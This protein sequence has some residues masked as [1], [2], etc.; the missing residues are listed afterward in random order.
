MSARR[1]GRISRRWASGRKNFFSSP[2]HAVNCSLFDPADAGH[3]A[4][5]AELWK[6]LGLAPTT[7][8]VLFAAVPAPAAKQPRE[9]LQ[10]FLALAGR[11]RPKH[12][13]R[14]CGRGRGKTGVG[15]G[16]AGRHRP[17]RCTF[18]LFANQSEMPARYLLR[19]DI[20]RAAFAR[21]LRDS[22][23]LAVNE[24][25]HMGIPCLVRAT[26]VGCQQNLVTDGE[27]G[28]EYFQRRSPGRSG[29]SWARPSGRSPTMRGGSAFRTAVLELAIAGY[30][31]AQATEGLM[32]A[33]GSLNAIDVRRLAAYLDG[34]RRRAHAR[35][36]IQFRTPSMKIVLNSR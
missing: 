26:R 6:S 23:G 27:T 35:V 30:T 31:Y 8:V 12:G 22:W 2:S 19:R 28:V 16:G 34:T 7:R 4:G 36:Y 18:S 3:R 14:L 9:L 5:A 1:T 29:R 32:A 20:L 11:K 21:R 33:L 10:A 24:A 25:M 17:E 13:A 15:G